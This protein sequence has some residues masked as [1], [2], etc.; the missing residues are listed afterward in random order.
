MTV[1]DFI[2]AR[3]QEDFT[4]ATGGWK[5]G[6]LRGDEWKVYRI[7]GD[8]TFG[9]GIYVFPADAPP[10]G[11]LGRVGDGETGHI[12]R[13]D[14]ARVQRQVHALRQVVEATRQ[15]V[16]DN[17]APETAILAETVL[18]ALASIWA[19]DPGYQAEWKP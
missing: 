2:N 16:K 14:P 15:A 11:D 19:D 4:I 12:E 5:E 17:H 9:E 7:D 13:H 8:P 1:E 10:H 6:A 18:G 3:L